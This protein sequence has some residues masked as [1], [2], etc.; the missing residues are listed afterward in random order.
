MQSGLQVLISIYI[1]VL[2]ARLDL[3]AVHNEVAA[4]DPGGAIRNEESDDLYEILRNAIWR[5][6]NCGSHGLRGNAKSLGKLGADY[7]R[8]RRN[9][10]VWGPHRH[11]VGLPPVAQWYRERSFA[12]RKRVDQVETRYCVGY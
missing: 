3:S 9:D 5:Q 10:I 6:R 11:A 7:T 1:A 8:S 2:F 4:S 12:C